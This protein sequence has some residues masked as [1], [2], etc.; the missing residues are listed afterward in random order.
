MG[1][2]RAWASGRR[3]S[4]SRGRGRA[5]SGCVK[6]K[7]KGAEVKQRVCDGGN[8]R[9]RGKKMP[10]TRSPAFPGPSVCARCC[11]RDA[12]G[13]TQTQA[14]PSRAS[15]LRR[16]AMYSPSKDPITS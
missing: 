11:A 15:A 13:N 12:A 9:P 8:K 3:T 1:E 14:L 10:S 6:R 4:K 2:R 5:E 16:E 7:R